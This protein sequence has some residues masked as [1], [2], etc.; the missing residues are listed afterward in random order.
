[1]TDAKKKSTF[2]LGTFALAFVLVS[3]LTWISFFF[4]AMQDA[5]QI[6]SDA[7]V[8]NLLA[9]SF[10]IFVFPLQSIFGDIADDD[11]KVYLFA[12]LFLN[13]LLWA[14]LTERVIHWV[15]RFIKSFTKL[16]HNKEGARVGA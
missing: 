7:F 13:P 5:G 12:T 2:R 8:M 14:V 4:A 6:A 15:K 16:F 1:M 10:Q 3:L 11:V 9:D